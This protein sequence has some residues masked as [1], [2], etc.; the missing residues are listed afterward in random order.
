[1]CCN[2]RRVSTHP[3]TLCVPGL[4]PPCSDDNEHCCPS[5][6]PVCDTDGGRCLP[7]NGLGEGAPALKRTA[8][9]KRTRSWSE[10]VFGRGWVHGATQWAQDVAQQVGEHVKDVKDEVAARV[11][12][13]VGKDGAVE[14]PASQPRKPQ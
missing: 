5:D 4:L 3:L 11:S 9:A 8:A 13:L 7:G 12:G 6:L 14:E 10:R 2:V 1:M